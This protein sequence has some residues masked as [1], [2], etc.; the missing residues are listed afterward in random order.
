MIDIHNIQFFFQNV[1]KKLYTNNYYRILKNDLPRRKYYVQSNIPKTTMHWGQRKLLLSEIE[2]LTKY[3]SSGDL[4]IYAG[5]APAI[6]TPML[7]ELF[8]QLKF[9]LIDP[10]PFAIKP[11]KNMELRNEYFTSVMAKEF[12]DK[13]ILFICDIRIAND[14]K[15]YKPSE[16]EV[17][18]DMLLQQKWVEIM[19]PKY[20]MLKF[21]LP[22]NEDKMEYLDGNLYLQPWGPRTTTETRLIVE[23]SLI[24]N[25]KIWD[26]KK[27]EEQMFYFNTITRCKCFTTIS[28]KI[29][30]LDNCYDCTSEVIIIN[31][32]LIKYK[33]I[34]NSIKY[35]T[36][37]SNEISHNIMKNKKSNI[38]D[39]YYHKY[40]R[41][42]N[43]NNNKHYN[44]NYT[45]SLKQL[46]QKLSISINNNDNYNF[47]KY[48]NDIAQVIN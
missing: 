9:I 24:N 48:L 7:A 21:R 26:C 23:K 45:Y 43:N 41:Q 35:I 30:H 27:Y 8:P 39:Y 4:V 12:I 18:N 40:L 3:S 19:R 16:K 33:Q 47:R 38:S 42:I 5:A 36:D 32:Y 46:I 15:H 11:T 17:K 1:D 28:I 2:F 25:K 29:P 37:F 20:S 31:N 10:I 6:H 44:K 13:D 22:W 34:K 14:T